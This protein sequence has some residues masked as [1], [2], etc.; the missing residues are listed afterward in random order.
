MVKR[1]KIIFCLRRLYSGK[2]Q[3]HLRAIN[4]G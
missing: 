4:P 2:Q 1:I 3:T